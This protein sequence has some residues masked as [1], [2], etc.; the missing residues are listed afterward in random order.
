MSEPSTSAKKLQWKWVGISVVLYAAFY[1]IP[2]VIFASLNTALPAAIWIFAGVIIVAA[3]A[4]YLS[5]GVTIVE[6]AIAGAALMLLFFAAMIISM[7]RQINVGAA[8]VGMLVIAV[9]VFL[10]SLLGAW[11]G[12]RA[13]KLW[14]TPTAPEPTNQ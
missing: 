6:P 9:G 4:G 11:I 7:P 1:L 2:L 8:S 14:K 5:E 12:E 10:L 13:Q 3:V